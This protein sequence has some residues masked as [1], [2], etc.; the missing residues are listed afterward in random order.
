M[1]ALTVSFRRTLESRGVEKETGSPVHG[2]NVR[3]DRGGL[4]RNYTS[5]T[6]LDSDFRR[7][8]VVVQSPVPR[9]GDKG[10]TP[11]LS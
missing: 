6:P 8:D 1:V 3:Q 11:A 7:N 5:L 10:G 9:H 2:G 4:K